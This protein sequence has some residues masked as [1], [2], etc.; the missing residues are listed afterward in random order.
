M[1]YEW[2]IKSLDLL[3]YLVG[4]REIKWAAKSRFPSTAV[5]PVQYCVLHRGLDCVP[6]HIYYS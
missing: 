2:K 3:H 4:F 5:L 6:G 1:V